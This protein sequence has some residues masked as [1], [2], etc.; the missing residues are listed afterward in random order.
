MSK[1]L[2]SGD[3]DINFD[4]IFTCKNAYLQK[5]KPF[6]D[7]Q[8]GRAYRNRPFRRRVARSTS[9]LTAFLHL[10]VQGRLRVIS[11]GGRDSPPARPPGKPGERQAGSQTGKQAGRQP[12]NQASKKAR[13]Q[14]KREA[15]RLQAAGKQQVASRQ[16]GKQH[17]DR[18]RQR[19]I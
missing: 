13:R 11:N 6:F 16:A 8:G 2:Q 4:R 9:T 14:R 12:G 17:T 10:I 18:H 5:S 7:A 3:L 19:V 1:L 15:A